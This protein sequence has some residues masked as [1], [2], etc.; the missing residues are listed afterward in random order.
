MN[1]ILKKVSGWV[2]RKI[3]AYPIFVGGTV[4]SG[5]LGNF[6]GIAVFGTAISGMF[7]L[8]ILFIILYFIILNKKR[9]YN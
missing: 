3:K 1:K 4:L 6:I 9:K 2:I 5:Y 7:P 8:S